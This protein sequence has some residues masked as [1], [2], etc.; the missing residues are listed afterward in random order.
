[1]KNIT[2]I[3]H[4]KMVGSTDVMAVFPGMGVFCWKFR[5]KST[6]YSTDLTG[7]KLQLIWPQCVLSMFG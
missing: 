7:Y 3:N 1:M 2:L 4:K 5:V 6:R